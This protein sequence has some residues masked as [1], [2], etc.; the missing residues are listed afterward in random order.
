MEASMIQAGSTYWPSW[1]ASAHALALAVAL[2]A[3]EARAETQI[4]SVPG[5]P[6]DVQVWR[7]GVFSVATTTSAV[8]FSNGTP[9]HTQSVP[10]GV[11]STWLGPGNCFVWLDHAALSGRGGLCRGQLQLR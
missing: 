10:S 7:P 11:V 8:L 6:V 5:V 2:G 1:R 9:I 3:L 4:L